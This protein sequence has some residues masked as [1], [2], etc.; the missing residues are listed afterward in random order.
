MTDAPQ[1][2]TDP[3]L[4]DQLNSPDTPAI[5]QG[6]AVSDPALLAQLNGTA[7][8]PPASPWTMPV[9][10]AAF[11]GIPDADALRSAGTGIARGVAEIP[12]VPNDLAGLLE[13]GAG[14]AIGSEPVQEYGRA[15][16]RGEH[17]LPSAS[18]I[19]QYLTDHGILDYAPQTN[20]GK[21]L[22]NIG[23]FAGNSVAFGA[24]G[25]IRKG[26][27]EGAGAGLRTIARDAVVGTG[28]GTAN[29]GARAATDEAGI[30]GFPKAGLEM[31]AA[32]LGAKG[33]GGALNRSLLYERPQLSEDFK[34]ANT[35]PG[36]M[37]DVNPAYGGFAKWLSNRFGA[38]GT[39][40][41]A[42][43]D[44]ADSL[45]QYTENALNPGGHNPTTQQFGNSIE[46]ESGKAAAQLSDQ[47]DAAYTELRTVI[48]PTTPVDITPIKNAVSGLANQANDP[49]VQGLLKSPVLARYQ[50]ALADKT[51]LSWNDTDL[52]R[53]DVGAL[54]QTADGSI[55]KPVYRAINDAMR[56]AAS[57]VQGG[58]DA[59]RA[60]LETA[61][62]KRNQIDAILGKTEDAMRP[63]T[64]PDWLSQNA[65]QGAS[66]FEALLDNMPADKGQAFGRWLLYSKGMVNGE[67]SPSKFMDYWKSLSPEAQ[68]AFTTDPAVREA[69]QRSERLWDATAGSRAIGENSNHASGIGQHAG[70]GLTGLLGGL[71]GSGHLDPSHLVYGAAAAGGASLAARGAAGAA[72]NPN[73]MRLATPL[74][75]N[76]MTA[77]QQMLGPGLS[78]VNNDANDALPSYYTPPPQEV[79]GGEPPSG[80]NVTEWLNDPNNRPQAL[81]YARQKLPAAA[82]SQLQQA[83]NDPLH[84]KAAL[85]SLMADPKTRQAI[86]G[87]KP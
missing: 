53:R 70:A 58:A 66:R 24:P 48:P 87:G 36:N 13:L 69:V 42:G 41:Q 51:S 26:I 31:L 83:A 76:M 44:T 33:S 65:K 46:T 21:A 1:P 77:R 62:N 25:A 15:S 2:I 27:A 59:F 50:T 80:R 85:F 9:E 55:Y 10:T 19:D 7:D 52:L 37:G 47:V 64:L 29:E 35:N 86:S 56:T 32:A 79:E 11:E 20:A 18:S 39:M 4:L 45:G 63:E 54:T 14:K 75:G 71:L 60:T 82:F 17:G 23:N 72:T 74:Q 61:T 16:L 84:W 38:Q 6:N 8:Q 73:M 43:N 81:A 67:F 5:G 68:Q 57:N 3:Q 49:A 28:A 22:Y 34:T 78:S 12:G 40:K 30:T